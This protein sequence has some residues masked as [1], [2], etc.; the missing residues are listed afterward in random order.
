MVSRQVDLR[1]SVPYP[2]MEVHSWLCQRDFHYF[3][4]NSVPEIAGL[5]AL[6]RKCKALGILWR[7]FFRLSPI[8]FRGLF[9]PTY[10]LGDPKST[11]LFAK[12]YAILWRYCHASR[13]LDAFNLCMARL[14]AYKSPSG[15]NF[16]V[17]ANR[18]LYLKLYTLTPEEVAPLLTAWAGE[19]FLESWQHFQEEKY[20]D[21]AAQVAGY[22]TEEHPHDEEGDG[23][24]FYYE[25]KQS[26]RVYNASAVISAFLIWAGKV[27]Q[28]ARAAELGQQ[29]IDFICSR[30]NEDGSWFSGESIRHI[31]GFHS[32]FILEALRLCVECT[33]SAVVQR[34]LEAGV[35]YYYRSLFEHQGSGEMRPRRFV[36]G[37]WPANSSLIQRVDLRDAALAVIL[38]ARLSRKDATWLERAASVLKWTNR[39]M[40]NGSTYA[41]EITWAWKNRIPYIEF[42]A[43][44]LL[45]LAEYHQAVSER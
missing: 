40:K 8:N 34:H 26:F 7:Q 44:M 21:M 20:L 13:F 23:V 42:Q 43:W 39:H 27:L 9:P 14:M 29:G 10:F 6:C 22:F 31:D 5:N 11:I 16:A 19:L 2:I 17:R 12:A 3:T 30:Q 25:P 45:A 24:Y 18:H 41:S 35:D 4:I 32:A 1:E 15:R 28:N 33:G 36:R 37:F 38:F